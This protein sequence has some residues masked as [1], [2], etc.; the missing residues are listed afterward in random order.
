M[1]WN[2]SWPVFHRHGSVYTRLKLVLPR[3]PEPSPYLGW[4]RENDSQRG[5]RSIRKIPQGPQ[6][7]STWTRSL[8]S[9]ISWSLTPGPCA[10]QGSQARRTW[11]PSHTNSE[12]RQFWKD[13]YEGQCTSADKWRA[14][15]KKRLNFCF[16]L[17]KVGFSFSLQEGAMWLDCLQLCGAEARKYTCLCRKTPRR[18]RGVYPFY[19]A[20]KQAKQSN[21][22]FACT[23]IC[24]KTTH[25]HTH[26]RE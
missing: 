25:T 12:G 18:P 2:S 20:Q 5:F 6:P 11:T 1:A 15:K 10:Q 23:F 21:M 19:N 9:H 14:R 8:S 3:L 24:D 16:F 26:T 17:L 13:P 7:L 4:K 22:L